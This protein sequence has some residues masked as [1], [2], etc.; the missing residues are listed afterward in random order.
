MRKMVAEA[1]LIPIMEVFWVICICFCSIRLLPCGVL[2]SPSSRDEGGSQSLLVTEVE[3][4]ESPPIWLL[5]PDGYSVFPPLFKV[6]SDH[7]HRGWEGNTPRPQPDS[8]A[9]RYMKRLY[10]IFATKEGIP[11]ANK[12][13]LYN[14]VRLFTPSAECQHPIQG[15]V[16]GR[17]GYL[18]LGWAFLPLFLH[19]VCILCVGL[20]FSYL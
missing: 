11:K 18:N 12:N 3:A 16:R 2:C 14:T 4:S 10:K 19:P 7:S 6:L 15:Q 20:Q 1:W 8:R 9:L 5:P 17:W 13:H